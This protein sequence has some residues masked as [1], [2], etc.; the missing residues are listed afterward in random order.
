MLWFRTLSEMLCTSAWRIESLCSDGVCVVLYCVMPYRFS[1]DR[2]IEKCY[3]LRRS[4]AES[5]TVVS[6]ELTVDLCVSVVRVDTSVPLQSWSNTSYGSL[7][8][9]CSITSQTRR[10]A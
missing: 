9:T 3:F 10:Q 1:L 8:H 7:G 2:L 6:D 4:G 5:R